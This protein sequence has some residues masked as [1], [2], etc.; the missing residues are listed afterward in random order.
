[1]K[2]FQG[3]L[4]ALLGGMLRFRPDESSWQTR[5]TAVSGDVL[6]N[7]AGGITREATRATT[8]REAIVYILGDKAHPL[9]R[10]ALESV[11]PSTTSGS[12]AYWLRP[13]S[14]DGRSEISASGARVN[15]VEIEVDGMR[16]GPFALVVALTE[17]WAYAC[18]ASEHGEYKRVMHTC[19]LDVVE[20]LLAELQTTFHLQRGLE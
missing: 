19:E 16:V 8:A 4:E 14:P 2:D 20:A 3:G 13:K 1:M 15:P 17:S 9:V 7:L 10:G 6:A 18:V 5:Q 12:A 11:N